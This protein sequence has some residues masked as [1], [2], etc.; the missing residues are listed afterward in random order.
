MTEERSTGQTGTSH[1]LNGL[2][3]LYDLNAEITAGNI[4]YAPFAK[5]N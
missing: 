2:D 5:E 1:S 4:A 3:R